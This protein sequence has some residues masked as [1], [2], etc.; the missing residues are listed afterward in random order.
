MT[1]PTYEEL[2]TELNTLRTQYSE[3]QGAL[4]QARARVK[5]L[6]AAVTDDSA[7]V[8]K[9]Q[10]ELMDIKLNKPVAAL[11]DDVLALSKYSAQELAEHYK[12]DLSDTGAIEMRDAE[13]KPV[14]LEEKGKV[15]PVAFEA[16][17]VRR[18]LESTGKFD[19]ILKASGANGS[20]AP[21]NYSP[22]NGN[23]GAKA[24]E[25]KAPGAGFGLK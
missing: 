6:E 5:E 10:A 15:R 1:E 21:V 25:R 18:F 9:L 23:N 14:A 24:P 3:L 7:A 22:G 11:L 13:G 12:F 4:K 20:G 17:D 19:H 8:D 16:Q 2:V